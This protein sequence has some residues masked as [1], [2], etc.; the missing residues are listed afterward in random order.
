MEPF[1][2][3]AIH[4]FANRH[5]TR[6]AAHFEQRYVVAAL[7]DEKIVASPALLNLNKGDVSRFQFVQNAVSSELL[8]PPPR[9]DWISNITGQPLY[10]T[11]VQI[12]PKENEPGGCVF[13]THQRTCFLEEV[14]LEAGE[15]RWTA[16]PLGCVLFP[17]VPMPNGRMAPLSAPENADPGSKNHDLL[18]KFG[19]RECCTQVAPENASSEMSEAVEFAVQAREER[20]KRLEHLQKSKMDALRSGFLQMFDRQHRR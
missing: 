17:L 11:L 12:D 6:F 8:G 2:V 15:H 16:K 20:T 9:N 4:E 14:A 10:Y 13:L 18:K 19:D 1:D 3:V 5:F 7:R